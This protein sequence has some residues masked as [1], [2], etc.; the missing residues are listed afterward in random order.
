MYD[1]Y[2][3]PKSLVQVASLPMVYRGSTR[4]KCC[5][6]LISFKLCASNNDNGNKNSK[7]SFSNSCM[8]G[9]GINA[10][11]ILTHFK[12]ENKRHAYYYYARKNF[13]TF[14]CLF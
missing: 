13:L 6:N 8:S 14:F 5:L 4:K 12:E 9:T 3:L 7:N 1:E 11:L 10:L 2:W